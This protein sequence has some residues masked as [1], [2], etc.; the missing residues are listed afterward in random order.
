MTTIGDTAQREI[1][2]TRVLDAPREVVWAAW[3]EPERVAQWWGPNGF[4]NTIHEMDVRP[5]GAWRFTMHGPDGTDYR[6]EIVY[7]EVVPPERLVYSHVSGPRFRMTATFADLGGKTQLAVQ[8]LFDTAEQ[9]DQAVARFGAVEGLN[10]TLGRLAALV[11]Q[12][13]GDR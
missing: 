2:T 4:T 3:T 5:G 7:E 9:R 6:N 10:Q 12:D 8:M 13:G 1:A 11:A